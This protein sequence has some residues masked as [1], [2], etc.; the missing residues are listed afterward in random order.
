MQGY[1]TVIIEPTVLQ[2]KINFNKSTLSS[3]SDI[4]YNS[5]LFIDNLLVVVVKTG[6]VIF[7]KNYYLF[8]HVNLLAVYKNIILVVEMSYLFI[9]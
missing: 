8:I 7:W 5:K 6:Y 1:N 4:E 3:K 9:I 2:N